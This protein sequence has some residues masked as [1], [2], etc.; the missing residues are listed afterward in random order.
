MVVGWTEWL[1]DRAAF[2]V[3]R[4]CGLGACGLGASG[5]WRNHLLRIIALIRPT[6]SELSGQRFEEVGMFVSFLALG[7]SEVVMIDEELLRVATTV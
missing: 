4:D 5:A 2:S 1:V 6:T 7:A 3:S